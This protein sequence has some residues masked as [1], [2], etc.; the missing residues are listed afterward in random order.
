MED[1]LYKVQVE[2]KNLDLNHASYAL[3]I[4]GVFT[5]NRLIY[6]TK[7]KKSYDLFLGGWSWPEISQSKSYTRKFR[8]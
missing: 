8:V 5:E 1:A 3:I 7:K 2:D 6:F 4:G